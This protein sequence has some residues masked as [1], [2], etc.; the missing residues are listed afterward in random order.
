MTKKPTPPAKD[1]DPPIPD[2]INEAIKRA[3]SKPPAPR[4]P[5]PKAKK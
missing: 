3:L 2:A 5:S 1:D 4:K